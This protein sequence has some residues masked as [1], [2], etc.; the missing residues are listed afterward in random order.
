M[1]VFM[2][3][4]RIV[5]RVRGLVDKSYLKGVLCWRLL[6]FLEIFVFRFLI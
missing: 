5:D 6:Y 1:F 2:K 4:V 3:I